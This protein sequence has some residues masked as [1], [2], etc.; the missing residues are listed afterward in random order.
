MLLTLSD[1]IRVI[2]I[3]IADRLHNMRTLGSMPQ[4]KQMKI[5]SE[6]IY[7]FAPLAHRLGLYNIKIELEELSL[8]YR[9]P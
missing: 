9:F 1:D 3:K 7:L 8:K 6:T 4:H 2:I 5:A